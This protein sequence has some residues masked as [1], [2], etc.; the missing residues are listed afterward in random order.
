VT[1]GL[2]RLEN[3][4]KAFPG[5]VAVKNVSLEIGAG[6]I[7][8]LVGEN[9]AGK[10]TLAQIVGG[11]LRPDSGRMLLQDREVSFG[12]PLDAIR[13]GIATVFQELS[14]V[15]SLSIAENVFVN[16]QPVGALN[17]IRW[18]DLHARTAALLARFQLDLDPRTPVKRLSKGQQQILEILKAL[19]T[20]PGL[21][22][23][24]EPTSSLTETETAFLFD[25]IRRLRSRGMAVLYVTHKL[26][27]VFE[28]ADRVAVL[29]DGTFVGAAPTART[30]EGQLISMMVGRE[31]TDVFGP[32]PVRRGRTPAPPHLEVV[33]LSRAGRFS[34]VSFAVRRGEVIGLA[35]LVGSGR[36]EVARAIVGVDPRDAGEVLLDGQPVR[37]GGPRDAIRAGLVYVTEDRKDLGLFLGMPLRDNLVAPSLDDFT[38]S[39]GLLQNGRIDAFATGA[40]RDFAIA[41]PSVQKKVGL[42][43]GGNQQK[44]LIA[45][46]M[47]TRPKV[48]LFDEPTRG[49]DVGARQDI[50]RK[51]RELAERGITSVLISSELPELIGMCD[52]ILVMHRG[53]IRG[54]V[55]RSDFSEELILSYATGLRPADT[56]GTNGTA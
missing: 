21:L 52:R 1:A 25:T 46:W 43:S 37:I 44:A 23:L 36:T 4:R 8:A 15:G 48:V 49:V 35:G 28:L 19:S 31:I 24:D 9:G 38:S 50:Y 32:P 47:G 13:A 14:M 27:E 39:S 11:V 10:S 3:V 20:D 34:N 45:A 54:E 16:R 22:L 40:V 12:A 42:L 33:G 5:V 55:Q 6:E 29:R 2:L 26:S 51:I 56:G 41:T 53:T 18:G 17:R 7:L 30:T